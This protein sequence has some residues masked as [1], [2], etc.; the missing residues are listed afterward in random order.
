LRRVEI[1]YTKKRIRQ[2]DSGEKSLQSLSQ[3][4]NTTSAENDRKQRAVCPS[5]SLALPLEG[6]KGKLACP[7][8]NLKG[9]FC[10]SGPYNF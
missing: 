2:N 4:I 6:R 7:H 8:L 9:L 1:T 5:C 10:F 3:D